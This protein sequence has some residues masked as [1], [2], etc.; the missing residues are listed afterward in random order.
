MNPFGGRRGGGGGGG[1]GGRKGWDGRRGETRRGGGGENGGSGR[2]EGEMGVGGR[3][4][5]GRRGRREK[6]EKGE[7][8]GHQIVSVIH[9]CS[10]HTF[11][12]VQRICILTFGVAFLSERF[13]I[14]SWQRKEV[15]SSLHHHKQETKY[16][17]HGLLFK[18]T[19]HP[20][21]NGL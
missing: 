6:G 13:I 21:L 17:Y 7:G 1:G 20:H 15:M 2:E 5:E 14:D 4:V 12:H 8:G 9:K 18:G 16:V 19:C 10:S 3:V 11:V